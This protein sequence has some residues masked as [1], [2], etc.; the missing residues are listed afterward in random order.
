MRDIHRVVPRKAASSVAFSTSQHQHTMLSRTTA[1]CSSPLNRALSTSGWAVSHLSGVV[2]K[3]P[4]PCLTDTKPRSSRALT[5]SRATPRLTSCSSIRLTS[6]GIISPGSIA[7][8]TIDAISLSKTSLC[9]LGPRPVAMSRSYREVRTEA[10]GGR[11]YVS[12]EI[13][14]LASSA[15]VGGAGAV[16]PPSETHRGIRCK[17]VPME[18]TEVNANRFCASSWR[19]HVA[20][21][22]AVGAG[23][24]RSDP[25]PGAIR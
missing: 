17:S 22:H 1:S 6:P 10:R 9:S 19:L 16:R 12:L 13:L 21:R 23:I 14:S 11:R 25:P 20:Q 7:P 2:T 4:L 18:P 8:A 5:V 3:A 15:Q 24:R